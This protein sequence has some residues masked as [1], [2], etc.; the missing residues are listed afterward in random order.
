[1]KDRKEEVK[2]LL[3]D[4]L[5][6]RDKIHLTAIEEAKEYSMEDL[7][8]ELK[9][10]KEEIEWAVKETIKDGR[11]RGFYICKVDDRITVGAKCVGTECELAIS[12]CRG[13]KVYGD[14]HTHPEFLSFSDQDIITALENK[15]KNPDYRWLR[16]VPINREKKT[17]SVI[18]IDFKSMPKDRL[19]E[20]LK[21]YDEHEKK[22]SK[23]M[24]LVE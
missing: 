3:R 2:R 19:D 9:A 21:L 1:M 11:E 17:S 7:P 14:I 20:L 5:D 24:A 8:D 12:D 4:I 22:F 15:K 23:L 18:C 10:V 13:A 16:V 6:L